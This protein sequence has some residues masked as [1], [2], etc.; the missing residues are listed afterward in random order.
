MDTNNDNEISKDEFHVFM[1]KDQMNKMKSRRSCLRVLKCEGL[2]SET[3][4]CN[5]N[6]HVD[7]VH[8]EIIHDGDGHHTENHI[9]DDIANDIEDDVHVKVVTNIMIENLFNILDENGD[10]SISMDEYRHFLESQ[11][12]QISL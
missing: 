12:Q 11:Q 9:Y 5:S 3:D 7:D 1:K 6:A 4:E 8:I 2:I 10:G